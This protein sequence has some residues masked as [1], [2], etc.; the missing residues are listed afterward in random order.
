MRWPTC[1]SAPPSRVVA[2]PFAVP[3]HADDLV[4]VRPGRR[5]KRP[6]ALLHGQWHL[7]HEGTEAH[8]PFGFGLGYTTWSLRRGHRPT[9]TGTSVRVT[10]TNTG[11]RSGSTV[12]QVYGSVPDSTYL[13]PPRRLIGFRRVSAEPGQT[14]AVEIPLDLDQLRVRQDGAWITED[15]PVQLTVGFH[16]GDPGAI[17]V[18]IDE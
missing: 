8:L 5:P 7:D 18:A 4:D 3:R 6:T 10:V 2:C 13:R 17:V 16:A 15:A 11:A 9:T 14:V 12:V 1:C